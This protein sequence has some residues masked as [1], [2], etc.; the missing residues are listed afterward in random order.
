MAE[1]LP[2]IAAAMVPSAIGATTLAYLGVDIA[3]I[4]GSAVGMASAVAAARIPQS[5]LRLFGEGL[6]ALML[7][8][9]LGTLI[10]AFVQAQAA[11]LGMVWVLS[12]A[13]PLLAVSSA[14]G[15]RYSKQIM[16][17]LGGRVTRAIE[18]DKNV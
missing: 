12:V 17:K 15:A 1:P 10:N 8:A 3:S 14:V 18:G 13:Y 11:T 7:G 16:Q 5:K 2:T 6:I 9:W 4:V